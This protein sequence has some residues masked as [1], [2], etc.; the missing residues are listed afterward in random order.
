MSVW[1]CVRDPCVSVLCECLRGVREGCVCVCAVYL[2]GELCVYG[3]CVCC[4][5]LCGRQLC[6]AMGVYFVSEI[7]MLR[8]H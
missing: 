4:V 7:S 6:V 2:V 3:E 5:S 8:G 1:C